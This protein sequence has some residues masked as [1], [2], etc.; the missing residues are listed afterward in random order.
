MRYARLPF[1]AGTIL[2][3]VSCTDLS[4]LAPS[5]DPAVAAARITTPGTGPWAR[6]VEGETGPGSQYAL[7]IPQN[8]NHEAIYYAHGIRPPSDPITLNDQDNFFQVRDA[9]G[10]LGY[11]F[12]YSS[13]SENGLSVKD[14]AQRTHQLRGLLNSELPEKA[15]RNYA[16]G[17]SLGALVALEL[18]ERFPSQ[19]DGVLTMCGMVGGSPSELQ[20][21]GDVRALFDFYYPGVM[22][23]NVIS[24]PSPPL[25]IPE[26]TG[27]VIAAITPT[28]ANPGAPLGL[29]AIASTS[30]TPLAYVPSGSLGVPSSPAFQTLVTSLVYA[31]YYQQIG[32]QDVVDRTHGHSPFD[33]RG[34]IYT[35]G[36]AAVPAPAL[37]P[38]IASMIAAS[39][40]GVARYDSPPDAQNYLNRNYSPTGN[41]QIPVVSVHNFWDPLVP[42]FHEGLLA[43]AAAAAGTSANLLRR[44]VPNYGHCNFPTPLVVGSFT[45]LAEWVRTGTNPAS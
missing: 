34:R 29:F 2:V 28:A 7:Y 26:I 20:Y 23:G 33:N 13:F 6:V 14:G 44:A 27:R 42:F 35:M 9:L 10:A 25:M 3:A 5:I 19:Y 36:T 18:G 1:L 41:L 15:Q 11:A 12:A 31:L 45:T 37:T 24:V 17:Y 32:T 22:P 30:Q 39:N 21:I 43:D 8:W 40:A 38:V 16:V 4:P